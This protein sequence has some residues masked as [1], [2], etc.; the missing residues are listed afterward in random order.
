MMI[1]LVQLRT[2]VAVAEEQHLTRAAERL[3]VSQS[4]AS[5]HVRAVEES[6]DSQLFVRT[7]RNLELTRAGQLLLEKAKRLLNEA[8]QFTSFARELRGKVD[9][10]LTVG[11]GSELA[12]CAGEIVASLRT[13]HPLIRVDLFSR[14]SISS[15]QGLKIGELDLAVLL[16]HVVDQGFS[17]YELSRLSFRVVGPIAWKESIERADWAEL[18]ALPWITPIGSS[19]YS[20]MQAHLFSDRGLE[21]NTVAHFDSSVLGREML[22]SGVGMMMMREDRALRWENNGHVASSPIARVEFPLSI[23]HQTSRRGDPLIDAFVEAARSLW[24]NLRA[25]QTAKERQRNS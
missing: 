9:G 13:L 7:N 23:A 3:H 22:R 14:P 19:A 25:S 4:A 21:L 2:F 1:D 5:A 16:G 20:E 15:K 8:S 10:N 18:A 17:V 11:S 12:A 24:P 6:L